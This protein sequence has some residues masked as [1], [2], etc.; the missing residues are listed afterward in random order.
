M[1]FRGIETNK[2]T[3]IHTRKDNLNEG[4]STGDSVEG[5]D[6]T[7]IRKTELFRRGQK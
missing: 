3:V 4:S 5:R 6:F 2:E 7:D 1:D